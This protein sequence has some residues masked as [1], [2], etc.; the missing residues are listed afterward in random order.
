MPKNF[1]GGPDAE[2]STATV[3]GTF[4]RATP[5]VFYSAYI[6]KRF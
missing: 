5:Q 6:F 1:L 3:R 4:F 2:K